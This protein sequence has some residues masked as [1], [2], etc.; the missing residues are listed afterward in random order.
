[1]SNDNDRLKTAQWILERNLAWI[2]GAEVKVGVIVAMNTAMLAG[3]ASAYNGALVDSRTAWAYVFISMAVLGLGS[4]LYCVAMAVLP[5]LDGPPKSLLFFGRVAKLGLADYIE[6]L[7]TASDD[8]LLADWSAQ[9]HRNAE[10]ACTK[11]G[12]VRTAMAW[13]FSAIAPWLIAMFLLVKK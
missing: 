1:M 5:R 8:D 10:I 11:F 9:I 2:N 12:W 3:L 13:S 4:S 6:A 7:R